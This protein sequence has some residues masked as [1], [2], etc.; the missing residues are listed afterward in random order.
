MST[1]R[2]K[3]LMEIRDAINFAMQN[4]DN[5]SMDDSNGKVWAKLNRAKAIIEVAIE[6]A[7]DVVIKQEAA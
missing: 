6:G 3:Y 1:I 7:D 4:L 5:Q 2:M